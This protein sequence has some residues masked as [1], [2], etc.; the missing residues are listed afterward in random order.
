M[1]L[2]QWDEWDEYGYD[3]EEEDEE[4]GRI[5]VDRLDVWRNYY[6]EMGEMSAEEEDA[7]EA[8]EEAEI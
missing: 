3:N 7:A 5:E 4:S 1:T 6:Q 2:G 8:D